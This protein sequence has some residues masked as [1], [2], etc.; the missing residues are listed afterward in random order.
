L[1]SLRIVSEQSD[2]SNMQVEDFWMD[3]LWC[4]N[5]NSFKSGPLLWFRIF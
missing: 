3:P 1:F 2:A 4:W 5:V